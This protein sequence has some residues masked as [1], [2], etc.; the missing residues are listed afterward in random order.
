VRGIFGTV[1]ADTGEMMR[2]YAE[3]EF[4]GE[5]FADKVAVAFARVL[6]AAVVS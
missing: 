1:P 4:I 3:A 5:W 6:S 2:R